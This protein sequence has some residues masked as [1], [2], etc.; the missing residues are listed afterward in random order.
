LVH[1]PDTL[2][3][4]LEQA[5]SDLLELAARVRRLISKR[6]E[7]EALLQRLHRCA[8][9]PTPA[10]QPMP[11]RHLCSLCATSYADLAIQNVRGATPGAKCDHCG[12]SAIV[13]IQL[14]SENSAAHEASAAPLTH[15]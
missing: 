3:A 4:E 15:A 9:L 14:K 11:A 12:Q 10:I 8:S 5:R 6:S 13:W 1:E 7:R 2:T